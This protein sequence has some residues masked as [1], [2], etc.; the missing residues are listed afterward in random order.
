MLLRE[1][2]TQQTL[3]CFS[4]FAALP[5]LTTWYYLFAELITIEGRIA[6]RFKSMHFQT[7]HVTVIKGNSNIIKLLFHLS[8]SI[9]LSAGLWILSL[10]LTLQLELQSNNNQ[11]PVMLLL[12]L[13]YD[14]LFTL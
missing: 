10:M 6:L 1:D 11:S 2:E 9:S 7:M 3:T 5:T 13:T 14:T 8:L 4:E 12:F